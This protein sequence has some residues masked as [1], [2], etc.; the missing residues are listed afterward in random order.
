VVI[1]HGANVTGQD[2]RAWHAE[3]FKRLYWA[4][5]TAKLVGI[6][7]FS[8]DGPAWNYY[9]NVKNAFKTAKIIGPELQKATGSSPVTIMAHSLGNM[10]TTSYLVDQYQQQAV[11]ARPN[12][13]GYMML[14]AAVP[15]EAF[16]G[17]YEAYGEGKLY[18]LF[19]ANN[20][21]VH[22]DW[23]GYQ[24]RFGASEWHQLFDAGDDRSKLTWRNRFAELPGGITY[25]NYYSKGE[26]VLADFEGTFPTVWD[27][28]T[29]NLGRN[30]WVLQEKWKGR[31]SVIAGSE[32]MGWGFNLRDEEYNPKVLL[33]DNHL[34]ANDANSLITDNGLLKT[35]PFFTKSDPKNSQL[36][37]SGIID[38][39]FKNELLAFALPALTTPVGGWKG[40]E[41]SR[42]NSIVKT[43]MNS[44][45][46]TYWPRRD[47]SWIH[48][49]IKE[50]SL[51][52][53]YTVVDDLT[54]KGGLR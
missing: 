29:F 49:D 21:M 1:I 48:S 54:V 11:A 46:G 25:V 38:F 4:G 3:L 39:D 19:D 23:F 35:K 12:I 52:Y 51:P 17:D 37:S 31:P 20:K 42:N 45:V 7:W 28:I 47:N 9:Q 32:H 14:N 33:L 44:A 13:T 27:T 6:S 30:A 34:N 15:L 41:I 5:S 18:E 24:K 16:L 10:L 40:T 8:F 43:D 53:I 50:V 26:D 22:S 36:F 2:A